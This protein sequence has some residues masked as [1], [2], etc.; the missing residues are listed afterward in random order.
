MYYDKKF[1]A[2]ICFYNF[3]P[4]LQV[5]S[6][7]EVIEALN[8]VHIGVT[9][10]E[11][12]CCPINDIFPFFSVWVNEHLTDLVLSGIIGPVIWEIIK[13]ATIKSWVCAKKF[14]NRNTENQAC[15]QMILEKDN[16]KI[17]VLLPRDFTIEQINA[18]MDDLKILLATVK[19]K[20][21]DK[22]KLEE[23]VIEYD[24]KDKCLKIISQSQFAEEQVKKQRT[25]NKISK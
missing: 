15:M 8:K 1:E 16:K 2:G 14:Y 6:E 23:T 10:V 11:T 19:V 4:F 3:P 18:C 7:K 20:D 5:N 17:H 21:N 13:F 24:T 12:R 22:V 9:F 25:E